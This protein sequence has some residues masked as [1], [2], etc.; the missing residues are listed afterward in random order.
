MQIIKFINKLKLDVAVDLGTANT[1]VAV[2]DKGIVTREPTVVVKHKK[3]KKIVAIGY[4]AKKMIG[5]TPSSLEVVYPLRSG[6]IADFDSTK[7]LLKSWFEEVVIADVWWK[8]MIKPRVIVGIPSGITEVERRAVQEVL[9]EAGASVVSL[10]EESMAASIGSGAKIDQPTGVM[11]V[12]I[13]GGTTEIAAISL[14][15]SVVKKSVRRAG[16]DIDWAII[17]YVRANMGLLIGEPT[18]E[19]VKIELASVNQYV[20]SDKKLL[21]RGRDL[22]TGIPKSIYIYQKDIAL[23]IEPILEEI[24]NAVSDAVEEIPPEMVGDVIDQGIVVSGGGALIAGLDVALAELT[25]M[26]VK[27]ADDPLTCVVRGCLSL[28]DMPEVLQKV[29]LTQGLR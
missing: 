10:V 7:Y 28:F 12:D 24:I 3:S 1:L 5:K 27:I 6:V 19:R 17:Q 14:S 25:K 9:L 20:S 16:V 22:E 26:P 21:I 13:G 4:E 23:A 2:R 15:G 18:A 29:K 8:W 11:I